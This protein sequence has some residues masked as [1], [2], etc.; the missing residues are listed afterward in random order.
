MLGI[1]MFETFRRQF[2]MIIKILA[3]LASLV[4]GTGLLFLSSGCTGRTNV[5]HLVCVILILLGIW[6]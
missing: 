4:I 2:F 1:L 3:T 5:L 6:L